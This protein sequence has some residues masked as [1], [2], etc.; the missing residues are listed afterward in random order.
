MGSSSAGIS[1]GKPDLI[2]TAEWRLKQDEFLAHRKM[3]V[4]NC[5]KPVFASGETVNLIGKPFMA[6][7]FGLVD[8]GD[9]IT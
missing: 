3:A 1:G 6:G 2:M 9:K 7:N 4:R 8:A 5:L